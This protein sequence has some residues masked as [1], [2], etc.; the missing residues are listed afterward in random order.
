MLIDE[1]IQKIIEAEREV[2]ATKEEFED[3]REE[4]RKN[5]SDLQISVDSYAKKADS[6][7]QE[8][9]M[10]SHK[11]ERHEKWFQQIADKIGVK[12]EY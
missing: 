5:F 1:D 2:F 6:Y 9:V 10:L 4:M 8:M 7:F 11:V 3:F 12:L